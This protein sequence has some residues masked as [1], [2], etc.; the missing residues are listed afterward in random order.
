[1]P[2][3]NEQFCPIKENMIITVIITKKQNVLK[4]EWEYSG[5]E[6]SGW[7]FYE[8]DSPGKNLMDGSFPG[9]SIPGKFSWNLSD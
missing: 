9:G 4:R 5:W 7:E 8:G 2:I 6:F 1:M 3:K